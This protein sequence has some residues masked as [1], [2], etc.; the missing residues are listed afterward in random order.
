MKRIL[1]GLVV[2]LGGILAAVGIVAVVAACVAVLM[3]V[4]ALAVALVGLVCV[5]MLLAAVLWPAAALAGQQR[6]RVALDGLR[7]RARRRLYGAK[8]GKP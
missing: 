5:A 7:E 4:V 2:W 6:A 3:V 8:G 1:L